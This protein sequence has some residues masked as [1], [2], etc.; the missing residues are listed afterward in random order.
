MIAP[1]KKQAKVL[2]DYAEGTLQSTPLLSQLLEARTA[3][4]LTLTTGIVLEVRSASF[5]R[6]R[7]LTCVAV[8]G[9]RSCILD[10]R[11]L[12]SIRTLRF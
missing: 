1:D 2:L 12:A 11:R 4:T 7:G 3:E 10:E 5:R 9:R 8:L 6:I